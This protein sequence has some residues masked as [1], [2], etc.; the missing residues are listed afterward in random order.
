[1]DTQD[2]IKM[3]LS[4]ADAVRLVEAEAQR[5]CLSQ[6]Q[7]CSIYNACNRVAA[8][9]ITSPIS[10]PQYDT[11]AM[12]GFALSSA[13]TETASPE[14]P[15]TFEVTATTTA[16]DQPHSPADDLRDGIPSCVE[17]MTGAPFP[18]GKGSERFDCC[19]PI[20]EVTVSEN[21]SSRRRHI[22]VW[23][24]ARRCQHRRFAGGDFTKGDIIVE[25]GACIQPQ[26]IMAMAS[27]GL[28]EIAVMRR[29]RVAVFSTG[30]ELQSDAGQ[31]HQYMIPDANGP[32]LT[33]IL[34]RWGVEVDFR[35]VVRDDREAMEESIVS[36]LDEEYD[37][38]V[39][40][41]AV[42][43]GRC[44]IIPGLVKRMGGQTVFHKVAVKPGHPV[45]FS[46]LPQRTGETAFF[47]LPGNPVAAAAC[48]RF[49]ALPYLRTL[50]LQR[51]E[52]PQVAGLWLPRGGVESCIGSKSGALT[53]RKE[54]DIFRPA[55]WTRSG[56]VWIVDDHSP[57]KTK[58][59]LQANCW[60]HIPSGVSEVRAGNP[61]N[62]YPF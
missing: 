17:I 46:M 52:E 21:Q 5:Y 14:S 56:Q 12:D 50:Q 38:I 9:T 31:A 60:A 33:S 24:P 55:I 16:G 29:P 22:S 49:F 6:R 15:V 36:A 26:H 57:G 19:V 54:P 8:E 20:E 40:S 42:S 11:S 4:Y 43:A 30:S 58:P 34:Q 45:L 61:V 7:P 41:G 35:G 37:M 2:N 18:V 28:R 23:R 32:Y 39:T 13:A 25:A 3:P 47:G 10:T 44:D 1:M 51:R 62:I 53:F 27:V 48:L 59:F